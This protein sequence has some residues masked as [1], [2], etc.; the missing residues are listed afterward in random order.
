MRAFF[1]TCSINFLKPIPVTLVIF[2]F[3]KFKRLIPPSAIN[4]FFQ[5]FVII[6]NFNVSNILLFEYLKL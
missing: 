4:G 5:F 1:Y 6:L 2:S 3:L